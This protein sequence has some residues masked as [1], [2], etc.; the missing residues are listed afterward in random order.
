VGFALSRPGQFQSC[1]ITHAVAGSSVRTV[2]VNQF[3]LP[4]RS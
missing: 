2:S 3:A 1:L 4:L